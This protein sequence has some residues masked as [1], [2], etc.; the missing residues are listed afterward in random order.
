MRKGDADAALADYSTGIELNPRG[1]LGFYNRAFAR[2]Y[3]GDLDGA[4]AV[5][6]NALGINPTYFDTWHEQ[7]S[8][9]VL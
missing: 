8:F 6:T 4:I 1:F 7:G 5:V 2:K 9:A 3:K